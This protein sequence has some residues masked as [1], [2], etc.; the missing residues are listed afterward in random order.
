MSLPVGLP[1][2]LA[3]LDSLPG[4][5]ISTD[6]VLPLSAQQP[7]PPKKDAAPSAL[8]ANIKLRNVEISELLEK[9]NV[10]LGYKISGKVSAEVALSVP[11]GRVASQAAYEFTG[12]VSSPALHLEGLVIR[13]LS[14]TATYQNGKLTLKELAG[15]IDQPGKGNGQPGTFLG[16]AVVQRNPPGDVS[17][18]FAF[19]RLPVGELLRAIPGWTIESSGLLA[20][21]AEFRAPYD[22]I[23]DPTAWNA[24]AR[25]SSPEIVVAG[26]KAT[27]F[28][29]A[30]DVGKGVASLKN[31]HVTIEGIPITADASVTLKDKYPFTATLR[32]TGTDVVDFRKLVP[33]TELPDIKGVLET[34]TEATGTG[35]PFT[36][37]A[38]GA[39]R[40]SELTLARSTANHIAVKWHATTERLVVSELKANLFGGSLSG[41]ADVPF[42]VDKGGKFALAFKKLDAQAATAFVGNFPVQIAGE[43]TGEV[44]GT[45]VPARPGQSRVGNLSVDLTAPRLTV[46]GIPADRLVG[47]AEIKSGVL[48]YQ[49]EGKTLGGS[50]EVKGS[51]PGPDTKQPDAKQPDAKQPDAK[52][53]G[54]APKAP[55]GL[56]TI[57]GIELSRLTPELKI[58]SLSPLRGR[59]DGKFS[60]APDLSSGAGRITITG[61]GWGDAILAREIQG[62]LILDKGV[63]RLR[64]L[65]GYIAGGELRMT[66][67]AYIKNTRRN[68]F[69]ISLE[70]VD[71]R[72]L[73]AAIPEL[74]GKIDGPLT[75]V[76]RGQ[77]G[78]E[79]RGSGTLSLARGTISGIAVADLRVPFD[80]AM[81]PGGYGRFNIRQATTY[82]GTGR[83]EAALTIDWGSEARVEGEVRMLKVPLRTIVPEVGSSSLFGNG[84]ITGR[85]VLGGTNVRSVD[86]LTGTLVARFSQTSVKEIPILQQTIPF[87]N[88]SGLVQPF[89]SGDVR[90]T[91]SRG[92][93]RIQRLVLVNPS[94]QLF[95]AGTITLK[96]QIDASVVA[97]TGTL[98]P[99]GRA[100][101]L[102][103]LRLP[104]IG[105]IPLSLIQEISDFLSNRTIKLTI[106]GNVKDPVVRLNTAALLSEEAVRFLLARYVVPSNAAGVLGLGFESGLR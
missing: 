42:S 67:E 18:S 4:V 81:S 77:L 87:L 54:E 51:Y 63:L 78:R 74:A 60:F 98:G 69:S 84:R 27:D 25:V 44:D 106:T 15:K 92:V 29:V 3:A 85:F 22:K 10:K 49:L 57:T 75:L 95:A 96:G 37:D 105:P 66:A 68:W 11:I 99:G 93:F 34:T 46:Q 76:A 9:L 13:D 89:Q 58:K 28:N 82:T 52:Q 41:S 50:F 14:A 30:L 53:P 79:M 91:L 36:F 72:R 101:Q 12:K 21:K 65:T 80:W 40:A 86:D 97:H 103:G 104:M 88:T 33:G 102:F 16:T 62:V 20:G 7:A 47:K 5:F 45:I 83:I 59:I 100:F 71:A 43:V 8:S 17:A 48:D 73:A 61:L 26:R 2:D 39:I 24:T 6:A 1:V 38:R 35:S 55:E 32:T 94:A 56:L 90:G 64:E 23:S 70:N 19:E 31:T